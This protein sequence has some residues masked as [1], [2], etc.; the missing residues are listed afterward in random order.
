M[1][2]IGISALMLLALMQV[3]LGYTGTYRARQATVD[4]ASSASAIVSAVENAALQATR[5]LSSYTYGGATYTS[6]TSTLVLELP[7]VDS[8]GNVL[9]ATYDHEIFFASSSN[10]IRVIATDP[11]SARTAGTKYLSATLQSLTFTYNAIDL[12]TATSVTVDVQTRAQ[13]GQ[14]VAQTRL[15]QQIYL[16]NN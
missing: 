7:A 12:T 1:V 11:S 14:L 9:S 4:T 2:V 13:T 3:L 10:A 16:R 5:I 15:T 8:S 6:G